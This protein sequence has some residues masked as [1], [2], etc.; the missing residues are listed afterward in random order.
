MLLCDETRPNPCPKVFI[1]EARHFSWADVF[2][3][4][5]ETPGK[6]GY[7]IGMGLNQVRHDLRE[8]AFILQ[9]RDLA[10]LIGYE[11]GQGVHVSAVY[12]GD[13]RI[14]NDYEGQVS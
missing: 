13:V 8:P 14:G 1:Q 3:G 10:L 6:Y 4:F 5:Q 2:P 12:A 7:C 9:C 11:G